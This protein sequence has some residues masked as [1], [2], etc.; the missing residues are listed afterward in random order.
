[1]LVPST[2]DHVARYHCWMTDPRLLKDTGTDPLT[3]EEVYEM[4]NHAAELTFIILAN[5]EGDVEQLPMIGDVN[6]FLKG[7]PGDK[8]FE[9]EVGV[10]IA[11]ER[12]R[13]KGLAQEALKLMLSYTTGSPASFGSPPLSPTRKPDPPIPFPI[14]PECLVVRID[15][16]NDSSIR[17]FERLGFV[18]TQG[19]NAFGE[20]EMRFQEK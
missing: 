2:P 19:P 1:M 7:D 10:M 20:K 16:G 9:A 17:L 3:L 13:G 11:E 15:Q 4:E 18:G 6:L 12:Y 14:R 8:D 5:G